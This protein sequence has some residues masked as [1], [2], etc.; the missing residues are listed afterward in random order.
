MSL[1]LKKNIFG[2]L[3]K[4]QYRCN[5]IIFTVFAFGQMLLLGYLIKIDIVSAIIFG[6]M[7]G[8]PVSVICQSI[9]QSRL[10]LNTR[11]AIAMTAVGGFGMLS[12]C[13]L[14]IGPLGLY[15]LLGMCKDLSSSLSILSVDWFWQ[16]FLLSPW[17]YVGMAIGCNLGMWLHDKPGYTQ[18]NFSCLMLY[19]SCNAGMFFGMYFFEYLAMLLVVSNELLNSPVFMIG[20]MLFGMLFGMLIFLS[21]ISRVF[22]IHQWF[23]TPSGYQS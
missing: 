3:Y 17:T 12:A 13:L 7:F 11:M 16:R 1:S 5:P 10:S 18:T 19:I 21:I 22:D 6:L 23:D 4:Q 14:E 9:L 8:L 15:G 20:M 2:D